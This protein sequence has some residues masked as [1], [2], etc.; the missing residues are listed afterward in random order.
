MCGTKDKTGD[1]IHE[2]RRIRRIRK[3]NNYK[4]PDKRQDN[5]REETS[6]IL[7]GGGREGGPMRGLEL[8][9]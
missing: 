2:K 5:K 6:C 8:I 4:T 1:K 3:Y 7:M 9:M